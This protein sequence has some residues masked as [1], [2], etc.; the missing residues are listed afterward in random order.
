MALLQLRRPAPFWSA[1]RHREDPRLRSS[2]IELVAPLE[3][4]PRVLLDRLRAEADVSARR[5]LILALAAVDPSRIAPGL[6]DE[7]TPQLWSLHGDDPD[8]GVHSA[9]E[10]LLRRWGHGGELSRRR[11]E[12]RGRAVPEG[13][14]WFVDPA[15]HTMAILPGP[16][17]FTMGSP[18]YERARDHYLEMLHPRRIDRTIAVATEEVTVEQYLEFDPHHS[19]DAKFSLSRDC[20]VNMVSWFDAARYCN[21]L[22][23]GRRSRASNGVIPSRSARGWP[24]P[25]TPRKS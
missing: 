19:Y 10:Y 1:M 4:E 23:R 5:A 9:V 25:T 3:V 2:L 18:G 22:A 24:C 16:L 17:S 8:P 12:L 6:Q 14:R 7:G 13:R 20:P 11:D 15:G 21:A